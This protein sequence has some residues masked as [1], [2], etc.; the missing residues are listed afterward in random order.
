MSRKHK[1]KKSE[2]RIPQYRAISLA[3]SFGQAASSSRKTAKLISAV[4]AARKHDREFKTNFIPRIANLIGEEISATKRLRVSDLKP[5]NGIRGR[6]HDAFKT[7][8]DE[9]E[10]AIQNIGKANRG[11]SKDE[12]VVRDTCRRVAPPQHLMHKVTDQPTVH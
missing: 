12:Q 10:D 4:D 1:T 11:F 2:K 6:L 5:A 3:R 9:M 7:L 8:A